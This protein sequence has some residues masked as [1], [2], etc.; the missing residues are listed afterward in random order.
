MEVSWKPLDSL[1][2]AGSA[3]IQINEAS[4]PEG[5]TGGSQGGWAFS[6]RRNRFSCFCPPSQWVQLPTVTSPQES[7]GVP[8]RMTHSSFSQYR[9]SSSAHPLGGL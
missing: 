5:Q 2:A 9:N 6:F 1:G 7:Q 3:L 8:K 4:G